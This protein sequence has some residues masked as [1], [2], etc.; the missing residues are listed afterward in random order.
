MRC[1]IVIGL[2]F[3]LGCSGCGSGPSV[4]ESL[5]TAQANVIVTSAES[6]VICSRVSAAAHRLYPKPPD[7]Q[8]APVS[9][10]QTLITPRAV[11][12]V[13]PT[14][15]MEARR[16]GIQGLVW[17]V[18]IIDRTG[19]PTRLQAVPDASATTVPSLVN[20]ALAAVAKW[21]FSPATLDNNPIEW[22]DVVP[23]VFVFDRTPHSTK[24]PEYQAASNEKYEE[25]QIALRILDAL[26]AKD[27]ESTPPR[28]APTVTETTSPQLLTAV[29]YGYP[30]NWRA[31]ME[32]I[33][34]TA[35]IDAEGRVTSVTCAPDPSAAQP[36]LHADAVMKEVSTWRFIPT[37]RDGKAIEEYNVFP[38]VT[39]GT[40]FYVRSPDV[41]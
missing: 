32:R 27:H 37:R 33:W 9:S 7:E 13:A 41:F 10:R 3:A 14:Y 8:A 39:N 29:K 15:P 26:P 19:T 6:S 21:Q 4:E 30:Q 34:V 1:V 18:M 2:I 23:I 11:K 20:A 16:R 36:L 28:T 24:P 12:T 31:T 17:V 35:V 38:V 22:L 40:D 25:T 5:L